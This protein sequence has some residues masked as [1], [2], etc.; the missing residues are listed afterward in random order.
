MAG[1]YHARRHRPG[2]LNELAAEGTRLEVAE[3]LKKA[4]TDL[5]ELRAL[6]DARDDEELLQRYWELKD[7]DDD[8]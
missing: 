1:T 5:A 4:G 7:E 8:A 3:A 6:I 2:R